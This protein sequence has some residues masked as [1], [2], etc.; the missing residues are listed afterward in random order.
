MSASNE[1]TYQ[2]SAD[3]TKNLQGRDYMFSYLSDLVQR[4]VGIYLTQEVY[5]RLNL[6]FDTKSKIS[7]DRTQLIV[8]TTPK[9]IKPNE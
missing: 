1:K 4:D 2:L 6:P 5:K 3:E 8:D 9:I 7:A